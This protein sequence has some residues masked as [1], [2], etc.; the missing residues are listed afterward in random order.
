MRR[1]HGWI[2][3][4]GGSRRATRALDIGQFWCGI[5]MPDGR[6]RRTLFVRVCTSP[7]R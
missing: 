6:P 4:A 2:A 7:R 1:L 3:H 5:A